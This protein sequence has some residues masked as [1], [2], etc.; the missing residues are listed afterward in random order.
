M[1]NEIG[2]IHHVGHVVRDI[3]NARELYRRLGFLCPAPAYPTLSRD[4]GEPARPFGAANMHATF[5][6]NFVEIMAVVTEESHLPDDALPS[7]CES[8]LR[9][10]LRWWQASNKPSRI[11]RPRLLALKDCTFSCFRRM[12]HKH[13]YGDSTRAELDIAVSTR[14]SNLINEF[15]WVWSKSTGKMCRK[16]VLPLRKLQFWR[17]HRLKLSRCIQME[18]LIWSSRCFVCL[19]PRSMHM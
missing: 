19:V 15:Q 5:A 3:A 6:R 10:F 7:R 13:L 1:P 11:S 18:P 17:H 12:M 14:C 2:Y 8:H 4:A 9:L 16:V